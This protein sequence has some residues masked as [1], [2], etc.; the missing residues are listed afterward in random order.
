MVLATV[1]LILPVD[2]FDQDF[3]LPG[4]PCTTSTLKI[5]SS[6]ARRAKDIDDH[7]KMNS[8]SRTI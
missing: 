8:M 4:W 3:T 6:K 1:K 5:Q 2:D 7:L